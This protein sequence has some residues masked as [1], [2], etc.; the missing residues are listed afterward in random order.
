MSRRRVGFNA[1]LSL[2]IYLAAATAASAH[3]A[4]VPPRNSSVPI[5]LVPGWFDTGRDMA[6]LRIRL[7]GAGWAPER[8]LAL[9]F[10]S[11]TG[12][13][14]AH[15]Q[16]LG[17]AIEAL[18]ETTGADQVD[19]VAHSM[20][21]LATRWYLARTPDAPVRRV[22]FIASPHR[23]T[24]AAYL[25]WGE[26]RADMVPGSPFLDSLNARPAVPAGIEAITV[27]TPVDTHILPGES[28]RLPSV[29]D[30][31]VCCP[32]HAGLL[33]DLEVFQIV[34]RFLARD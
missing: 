6:T 21:G 8:V 25:A 20:G 5:V 15:A 9:T 3:T 30:F 31:E 34:R 24:Y 1:L 12:G 28:A 22:A 13:N 33:R 16:E 14:R 11:P 2:T 26:G 17:A 19:I 23:G 29:P 4:L 7:I 10:R 32:T 18:R 27:R